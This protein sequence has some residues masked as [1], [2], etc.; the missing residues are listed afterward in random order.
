MES[1][2]LIKEYFDDNHTTPQISFCVYTA[3]FSK[4]FKERLVE[5]FRFKHSV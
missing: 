1:R 3:L 4:L 2:E 5:W